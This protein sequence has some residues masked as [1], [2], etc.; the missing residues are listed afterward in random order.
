MPPPIPPPP[1]AKCR[2]P[3][4]KACTFAQGG[5]GMGGGSFLV[6]GR[7]CTGPCPFFSL[8]CECF[9]LCFFWAAIIPLW[10][11]MLPMQPCCTTTSHSTMS[12]LILDWPHY[13]ISTASVLH[14]Y[15]IST[16]SSLL[17]LYQH[18]NI[19]IWQHTD[20]L[21]IHYWYT[22]DT[23]LI[24]YWYT[25]D[26]LLVHYCHIIDTSIAPVLIQY[27]PQYWNSTESP[28]WQL[29]SWTFFLAL[30]FCVCT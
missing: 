23:L 3:R 16:A 22:T 9:G 8:W 19:A 4:G 17:S 12:L 6:W 28:P 24:H 27:C 7:T 21:L 15:C 14:Q 30:I 13:C 26:T 18:T 10:C 1:W 5:G 20:T 2:L 25:T 11:A 29:T